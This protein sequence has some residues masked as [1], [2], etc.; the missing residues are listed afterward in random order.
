MA[1]EQYSFA[2]PSCV[3]FYTMEKEELLGVHIIALSKKIDSLLSRIE[4]EESIIYTPETLAEK[5]HVC[6]RTVQD[7]RDK[8]QINFT[9]LGRKVF[10]TSKDVEEFLRNHSTRGKLKY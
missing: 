1:T 10:F 8:N 9:K 2:A 7:W 6:I 4:G 3:K 5:L